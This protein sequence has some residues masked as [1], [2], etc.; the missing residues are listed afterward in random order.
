MIYNS[1]HPT[2]APER[3][4]PAVGVGL[5]AGFLL[6]L[7][8]T[9]LGKLM[10]TRLGVHQQIKHHAEAAGTTV[11]LVFIVSLAAV[12][13]RL[14]GSFLD[15]LAQQQSFILSVMTWIAPGVIIGGQLGPVV[16]T[17]IPESLVKPYVGGL[18][19]LVSAL[20][21]YRVFGG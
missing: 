7:I 13:V 3:V 1:R 5:I 20:M 21:F 12:L 8:A 6:G 16:S 14:N 11:V 4:K 2:K 15:V 18:L 9:G 19:V 17:K 10:V